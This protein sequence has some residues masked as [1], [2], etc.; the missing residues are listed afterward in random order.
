MSSRSGRLVKVFPADGG[1]R[2]VRRISREEAEL[3]VRMEILRPE[4]DRL[5]GDLLGY[6]V[7]GC[8]TRVDQDLRPLRT[9]AAISVQEMER[10]VCGMSRTFGLREADR[11]ARVR[12]GELPEDEVERTRAKVRVYPYVGA[13]R[14]DILRMWPARAFRCSH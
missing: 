4:F 7:P 1:Y 9:S 3:Q 10:F 12:D 6:R 11:M 2:I 14:G 13:A 5:S 8:D